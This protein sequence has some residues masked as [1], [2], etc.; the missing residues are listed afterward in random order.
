MPSLLTA[1][2]KLIDWFGEITVIVVVVIIIIII[3]IIG[4]GSVQ[5]CYGYCKIEFYDCFRDFARLNFSLSWYMKIFLW[6]PIGAHSVIA[7]LIK[8]ISG[9]IIVPSQFLIDI[10][11]LS[12]DHVVLASVIYLLVD[13]CV[14]FVHW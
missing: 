8:C 13:V 4:T 11:L 1:L 2:W 9:D 10:D 6:N 3:I 5:T 7:F 14:A 12:W